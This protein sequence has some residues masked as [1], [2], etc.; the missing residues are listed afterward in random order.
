MNTDISSEALH[1]GL[2][3]VRPKSSSGPTL[4]TDVLVKIDISANT[5]SQIA[6]SMEI[7]NRLCLFLQWL[8]ISHIVE[9]HIPVGYSIETIS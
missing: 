1:S 7:T 6:E 2:K 4:D 8:N 3:N 5:A 9:L